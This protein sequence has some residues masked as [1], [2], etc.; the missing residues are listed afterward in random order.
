MGN[1]EIKFKVW[2]GVDYMSSP[3]TLQDLQD[4][5]V[6]FTSDC[7][8]MQFTGRK[9]KKLNPIY[10][11][12]ILKFRSG[13]LGVVVFDNLEV[14]IEQETYECLC[15]CIKVK[16]FVCAIEGTDEIIGNVFLNPEL[17]KQ[18]P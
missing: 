6:Q 17:L 14:E 10:E 11:G 7:K 4:K 12:D 13:M 15:F 9:D 3:F 16:D 5:K 18:T 8:V 2:D 1:R